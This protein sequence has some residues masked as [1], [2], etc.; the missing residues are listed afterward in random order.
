MSN[1]VT[2]DNK[3]N[4]YDTYK[5]LDGLEHTYSTTNGKEYVTYEGIDGLEHT[6]SKNDGKEYVTYEGIDGLK[7]T[8]SKNGDETFTTYKGLD[9]LEHTYSNKGNEYVSHNSNHWYGGGYGGHLSPTYMK[10]KNSGVLELIYALYCAIG[11]YTLVA[12]SMDFGFA[13]L[14]GGTSCM[15]IWWTNRADIRIS[16]SD[17]FVFGISWLLFLY[18]TIMTK[19]LRKPTE[20][21]VILFVLLAVIG[22]LIVLIIAKCIKNSKRER[23]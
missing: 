11:L 23:K 21:R 17:F 13:I 16:F 12:F 4:K 22:V 10:D 8:Y 3:G 14:A 15:I 18:F 1:K 20:L 5:G 6:Y 7:H 2:Y 19:T 9:G